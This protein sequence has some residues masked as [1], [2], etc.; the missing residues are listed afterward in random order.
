MKNRVNFKKITEFIK[1]RNFIIAFGVFVLTI[2]SIGL[3]Y[4]SFFSVK[5]NTTNQAITTG[6]LSVS[7]G[8]EASAIL[9]NNMQTMS[10][11]D[12]L[13]KGET[14]VV[15]IQNT[16][17]LDSTF[18]LNIGYDMDNFI[19]R[20][21]YSDSDMLTPLDYVMVAVYQY[22]GVGKEDTLIGEPVAITDLPIYSLNSSDYRYNRYT[23]NVSSVG[24]TSS[25]SATKTYKIKMWLSDKAIPKA[26]Y[27]YF[28]IN[29]EV[30]AEVE[31]AKMAYTFSGT[32]SD[33]TANVDGAV[34]NVQN[35]SYKVS[36]ADG[37]KFSIPA[38]YPGTYNFDITYNNELYKGNLTIV[39]GSSNALA[40]F[41]TTF[42]GNNIYSI[43]KNYGTTVSRIIEKNN[44]NSYS[45][46]A[47]VTSGNL[48]PTYKFTGGPTESV[49]VNISL[50]TTDKTYTMSL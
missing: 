29:T 44:I 2:F 42:S 43:S 1:K 45:S 14:T 47:N 8:N 15:Y 11:E 35:G 30:V 19:N 32:L 5:T 27:S 46:E 13:K 48:Y 9:K 22:N 20:S 49:T 36:S 21:G 33:G 37:G 18:T 34:I 50:N 31:Q 26:S 4:A 7:Y 38:L 17:S 12:G 25:T 39:E 10:N 6:T 24:S 16:G 41:G 3:S 23:L 40:S 28:Y